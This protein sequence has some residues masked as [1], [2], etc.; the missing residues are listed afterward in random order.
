MNRNAHPFK[1]FI[2]F[3]QEVSVSVNF[4]AQAVDFIIII[5]LNFVYPGIGQANVSYEWVNTWKPKKA[6]IFIRIRPIIINE[7][8]GI[9]FVGF[10]LLIPCLFPMS[11][12]LG[13]IIL[14]HDR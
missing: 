13:R 7:G 2:R 6:F 8:P 10:G 1:A 9:I 4:R 5:S 11:D 12:K 3:R 14:F